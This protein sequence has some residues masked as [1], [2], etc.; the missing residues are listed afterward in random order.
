MDHYWICGQ[1]YRI[2]GDLR[3]ICNENAEAMMALALPG[4]SADICRMG[5]TSIRL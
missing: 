3:D 2:C 1:Y 4:F 5:K